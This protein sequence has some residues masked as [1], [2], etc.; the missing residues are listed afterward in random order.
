MLTSEDDQVLRIGHWGVLAGVNQDK[1]Y[2][3]ESDNIMI[4]FARAMS[5]KDPCW[6]T[7]AHSIRELLSVN[8]Q[9]FVSKYRAQLVYMLKVGWDVDYRAINARLPMVFYHMIEL[10]KSLLQNGVDEPIVHQ[11]IEDKMRNRF[12]L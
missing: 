9:L 10:A 5:P 6:V 1:S 7:I 4:L 3:N 8:P 11:W 12:V 2:E